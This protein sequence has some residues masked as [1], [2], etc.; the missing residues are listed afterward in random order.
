MGL[1]VIFRKN[2]KKKAPFS[3]ISLQVQ[4]SGEIY[5]H[6]YV[7]MTPYKSRRAVARKKLQ[8]RRTHGPLYEISRMKSSNIISLIK[9]KSTVFGKILPRRVPRFASY[10]LRRCFKIQVILPCSLQI[11]LKQAWI[12]NV[13]IQI[14]FCHPLCLIKVCAKG[15]WR[16]TIGQSQRAIVQELETGGK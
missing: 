11:L 8:P 12:A 9:K 5:K 15:F 16:N 14:N 4:I 1:L 2:T 10:W 13:T 6:R 7:P 3:K